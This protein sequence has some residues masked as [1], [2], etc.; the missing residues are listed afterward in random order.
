MHM[1]SMKLIEADE[2]S[3]APTMQALL[4]YTCTAKAVVCSEG[5]EQQQKYSARQQKT[6]AAVVAK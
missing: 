4:L 6:E 3:L 5:P 2:Q 1:S